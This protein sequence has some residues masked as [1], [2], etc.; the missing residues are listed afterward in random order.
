MSSLLIVSA[1]SVLCVVGSSPI[2]FSNDGEFVL[3]GSFLRACPPFF[4]IASALMAVVDGPM[5][6]TF[7]GACSVEIRVFSVAHFGD[8]CRSRFLLVLDSFMDILPVFNGDLQPRYPPTW[9]CYLPV[10][11]P[12]NRSCLEE[13]SKRGFTAQFEPTLSFSPS[14]ALPPCGEEPVLVG[15]VVC[16]GG[17]LKLF[18]ADGDFTTP[19]GRESAPCSAASQLSFGCVGLDASPEGFVEGDSFFENCPVPSRFCSCVVSVGLQFFDCFGASFFGDFESP[20]VLAV[21]F[22]DQMLVGSVAFCQLREQQVSI[23]RSRHV[24]VSPTIHFLPPL[25]GLQCQFG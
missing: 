16:D 12:E 9:R 21:P 10:A 24:S 15:S 22:V 2:S 6:V 25:M 20:S 13:V 14:C 7:S 4:D 5:A 18:S 11:A 8:L 1:L 19:C 3:S 23:A 17:C